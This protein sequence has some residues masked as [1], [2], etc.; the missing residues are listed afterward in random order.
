MLTVDLPTPPARSIPAII[1]QASGSQTPL[2]ANPLTENTP[3]WDPSSLTPAWNPSTPVSTHLGWLSHPSLHKLRIKLAEDTTGTTAP[4]TNTVLELQKPD[5]E[6]ADHFIVGNGRSFQSV[7]RHRL[8][9]I[10]PLDA[11]P[12]VTPI[13]GEDVGRIFKIRTW[14]TDTCIVAPP[15]TRHKRDQ[16][17]ELT[18]NLV[19]IFPPR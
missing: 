4:P 2:P 7:P 16:C 6:N 15:G 1:P 19:E 5:A 18:T 3:A 8:R 11:R 13:S 17:T 12:L 10:H 9:A 14:S